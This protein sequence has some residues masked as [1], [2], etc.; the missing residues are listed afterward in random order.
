MILILLKNQIHF[1]VFAIAFGRLIARNLKKIGRN[2]DC[3]GK[4]F[5]Q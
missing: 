1:Y 4:E 5:A 2:L 3:G